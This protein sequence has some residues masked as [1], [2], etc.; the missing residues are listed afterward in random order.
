MRRIGREPT[1]WA[2]AAALFCL[3][4]PSTA[5]AISLGALTEGATLTSDDGALTFS[6]FS[7]AQPGTIVEATNH[8]ATLDLNLV[9]VRLVGGSDLYTLSF[10]GPLHVKQGGLGLLGI[11]YSVEAKEGVS[12]VGV[13]LGT[14]AAVT[15]PGARIDIDEVVS[16]DAEALLMAII[17][18]G[19]TQQPGDSANFEDEAIQ[20]EID[21]EI[22]IDGG[23]GNAALTD[24]GQS[25]RVERE[26]R[27]GAAHATPEPG[28]ALLFAIGLVLAG[29][30]L[31]RGER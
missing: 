18:A 2:L 10:L 31:R 19:G 28:S 30:R 13:G 11:Q 12:I 17:A 4:L 27:P 5:G 21:T 20:L 14:R 9:E 24:L 7:V 16:G 26:D 29:T 15:D 6:G 22:W 25:F 3:C 23:I 1:F 8:L